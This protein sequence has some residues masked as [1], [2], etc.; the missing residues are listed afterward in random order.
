MFNIFKE[1]KKYL[2]KPESVYSHDYTNGKSN[3]KDLTETEDKGL[4]TTYKD[5]SC[6]IK[7]EIGRVKVEPIIDRLIPIFKNRD[8]E[9]ISVSSNK[10]YQ[11]QILQF[12]LR[13]DS[14]DEYPPDD[15]FDYYNEYLGRQITNLRQEYRVKYNLPPGS[16]LFLYELKRESIKAFV[17]DDMPI[18]LIDSSRRFRTTGVMAF[19][20][21]YMNTIVL[22]LELNI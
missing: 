10:G 3:I 4:I 19:E 9:I 21:T 2:I 20:E 22:D 6:R 14:T 1:I 11:S 8:I 18:S 12:Y 17:L 15:I 16:R 13:F 5:I 7:P